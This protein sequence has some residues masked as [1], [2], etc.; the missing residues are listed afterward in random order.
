M[1]SRTLAGALALV[2]V[3]AGLSGCGTPVTIPDPLN[4]S[5]TATATTKATFSL[6]GD[7]FVDFN[8]L[9][10]KLTG[11]TDADV[12]SA[13]DDATAHGDDVGILCWSTVKKDLPAIKTQQQAKT[14]GLAT[15]LQ[16]SRDL[17]NDLPK[18][19]ETCVTILPLGLGSL[20][21]VAVKAIATGAP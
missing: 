17:Q 6:T 8:P 3:M 21:P 9:L 11:F 7:P 13:L 18:L 10:S 20:V 4:L 2:F 16:A 1:K 12:Q 14:V 15:A 19:G 5:G